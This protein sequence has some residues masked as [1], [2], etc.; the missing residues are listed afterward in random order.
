M[1]AEVLD[2]QQE[3]MFPIVLPNLSQKFY[4]S[5]QSLL[6]LLGRASFR[7]YLRVSLCNTWKHISSAW[8][9]WG[10]SQNSALVSGQSLLWDQ[11]GGFFLWKSSPLEKSWGPW[12]LHEVNVHSCTEVKFQLTRNLH[13][14]SCSPRCASVLAHCPRVHQLLWGGKWCFSQQLYQ[15]GWHGPGNRR[16]HH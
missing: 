5:W 9:N 10:R 15:A 6:G 3:F 13:F 4:C 1:F 14:R 7:T 11:Q 8:R 12:L 2:P 16:K